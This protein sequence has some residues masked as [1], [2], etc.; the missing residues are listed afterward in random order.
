MAIAAAGDFVLQGVNTQFEVLDRAGHIQGSPI[1][2]QRFFGV[3]NVTNA[4][5][6][7]CDVPTLAS[8]S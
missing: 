3:P 6:T 1:G 5:G 2:G 4:D 7:P 8:R